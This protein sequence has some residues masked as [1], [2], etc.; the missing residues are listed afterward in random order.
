M[1]DCACIHTYTH[2]YVYQT[3]QYRRH[4]K[5]LLSILRSDTEKARL[6]LRGAKGIEELRRLA[7]GIDQWEQTTE[8]MYF[9]LYVPG[10][11]SILLVNY[12][13]NLHSVDISLLPELRV[14]STDC[15][16]FTI[17]S[18]LSL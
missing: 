3:A 6:V 7:A 1:P 14:H 15:R 5:W 18:E 10:Q 13:H 16:Y 11:N 9:H 12:M 4:P 8:H 2:T 17:L